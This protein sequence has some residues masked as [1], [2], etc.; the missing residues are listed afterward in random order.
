MPKTIDSFQGQYRFLSNFFIEPDGTH[1]EG[2][3]QSSKCA[4]SGQIVLFFLPVMVSPGKAKRLG[5]KVALR[6]DWEQVKEDIM[7]DLVMDKFQDHPE[8]AQDLMDT[9]DAMLVEGNTWGDTYWGVCH[10]V[11]KNRLGKI[12]MAVRDGLR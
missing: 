10:G 2:E 7:T 12:L 5:R 3:Y 11:G 4:R 6:P 9:G 8:L 1:V